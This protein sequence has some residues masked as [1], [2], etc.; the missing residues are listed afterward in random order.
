M[1]NIKKKKS[2]STKPYSHSTKIYNINSTAKSKNYCRNQSGPIYI[3][4]QQAV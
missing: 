4:I 1:S 3:N 2:Y